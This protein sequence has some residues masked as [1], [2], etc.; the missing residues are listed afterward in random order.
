VHTVKYCS[1]SS[2]NRIVLR[3]A[4]VLLVIVVLA[5]CGTGIKTK[6]K[7]QEAIVHRLETSSGLDMKSLD[8]TTTSVTFEKNRAYATVAFHPKSDP[9]VNS[10][11]VMKYTL[12]ARD[13]KWVVV[14]VADSHGHGMAGHGTATGAQL[15]PGH[16]PVDGAA[17]AGSSPGTG[18]TQ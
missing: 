5:G 10:D 8:L 16:P 2:Y 1:F 11:M 9:R 3:S 13:G 17:G 4:P 7:V 18:P 15:P 12:E 6:E 14:N